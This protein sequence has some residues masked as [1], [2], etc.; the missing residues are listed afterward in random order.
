M[1][2][3]SRAARA[4]AAAPLR[5]GSAAT[6]APTPRRASRAATPPTAPQQAAPPRPAAGLGGGGQAGLK[7]LTRVAPFSA[8]ERTELL[9]LR[10]A[11]RRVAL[12][13]LEQRPSLG[14]AGG[15]RAS[16]LARQRR[17][18]GE[19]GLRGDMG[20]HG[21]IRRR[22][23]EEGLRGG[24]EKALGGDSFSRGS[25]L[26][27]GARLCVR[28]RGRRD[29]SRAVH[30]PAAMLAAQLA[31]RVRDPLVAP[32]CPLCAEGL[33]HE[34]RLLLLAGR[35]RERLAATTA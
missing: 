29:A 17:R 7:P 19:E 10:R 34:E 24:L 18:V 2:A 22:V 4:A 33:R 8:P 27:G 5:E 26:G 21:E 12:G 20:R 23:G 11:E 13:S 30:Q 16:A 25:L 28:P 14:G 6:P 31:R 3:A 35:A 32:L 15:A 1:T 9:P